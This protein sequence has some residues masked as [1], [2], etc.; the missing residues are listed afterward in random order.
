MGWKGAEIIGQE[1]AALYPEAERRWASPR[2]TCSAPTTL[3]KEAWR[4][5][6]DGSEFLADVTITA[7]RDADGALRGFGHRRYDIT[8]RKAA[9][10]ALGAASIH[11]RSILATVPDAMIVIDEPA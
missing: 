6:K 10:R 2:P 11:V 3:R 8:D 7:L 4:V 5:R 9:E 1:G